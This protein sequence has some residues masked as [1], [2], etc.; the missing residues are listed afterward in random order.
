[1]TKTGQAALPPM[2]DA[3]ESFSEWLRLHTKEVTYGAVTLLVVVGGLW[4]YRQSTQLKEQRAERAYSDAERSY[5]SGNLPL[6]Q[7]DLEKVVSRYN[8][9][10]AGLQA[11]ELL[12]Q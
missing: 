7:S 4:L 8:G 2:E 11:S 10:P 3:A 6:A 5:A 12:A 9:T 1:M